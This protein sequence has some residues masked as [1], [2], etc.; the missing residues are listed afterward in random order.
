MVH[1]LPLDLRKIIKEY[2]EPSDDDLLHMWLKNDKIRTVTNGNSNIHVVT[3]S[4]YV[5]FFNADC[6]HSFQPWAEAQRC[7]RYYTKRSLTHDNFL[8]VLYATAQQLEITYLKLG[9]QF[10]S[11]LDQIWYQWHKTIVHLL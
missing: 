9:K 2:A 10:T 3:H 6:Q 8:S 5:K 7:C 11:Q 1:T 4:S